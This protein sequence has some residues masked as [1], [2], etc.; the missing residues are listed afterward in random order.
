MKLVSL[1][2]TVAI[3]FISLVVINCTKE[4]NNI[5]IKSLNRY[6]DVGGYKLYLKQYGINNSDTIL[7]F[8]SGYGNDTQWDAVMKKFIN[9]YNNYSYLRAGYSPSDNGTKPRNISQ[10]ETELEK[11]IDSIGVNK[12]LIMIGHSFGGF[13]IRDYAIKNSNRIVGLVFVDPVHEEFSFG[14]LTQHQID[15]I[16]D[17]TPGAASDE[18]RCMLDNNRYASQL[19]NLPDYPTIII[20]SM[21]NDKNC[22]SECHQEWYNAHHKLINGLTYYKHITT[23]NSGHFIQHEEPQLVVNAI[24]DIIMHNFN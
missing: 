5:N 3:T 21:K 14:T 22:D 24:N 1:K 15:S 12:K 19:P 7:F 16:C 10:I 23:T 11:L 4:D 17:L 13:I 18:N 20:T 6:V 8:E 9:K 2:L